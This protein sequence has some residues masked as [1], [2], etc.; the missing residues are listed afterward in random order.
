M[1]IQFIIS[2]EKKWSWQTIPIS[3]MQRRHADWT[4]LKHPQYTLHTREAK[5]NQ[6]SSWER[7]H[8]QHNILTDSQ[9]LARQSPRISPHCTPFLEYQRW[10]DHRK[11][12]IT[13][14]RQCVIPPK[15]YEW[16]LSDLHHNHLSQAN[17]YWP[18]MD[19]NIANY[20]NQCKIF[21]QHKAKQAVQ[22]MLSRDYQTPP[23][24]TLPL[25][26]S[27]TTIRNTFSLPIP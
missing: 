24:K 14:R 23:A 21:T 1:I 10:A 4:T 12:K 19:A 13:K 8:K 6:R 9:W 22:P 26:F 11:W 3:T 2:Q 18:R 5:Y 25:T 16:T 27:H 20:I 17:V 7:S 15:L